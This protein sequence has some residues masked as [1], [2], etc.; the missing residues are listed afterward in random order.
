M[1]KKIAINALGVDK[2]V[3]FMSSNQVRI[4]DATWDSVS[5]ITRKG[6]LF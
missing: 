5:M 2:G 6:E 4:H 3:P 1:L